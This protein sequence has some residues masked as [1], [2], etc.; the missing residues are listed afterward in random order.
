VVTNIL[1]EPA[2]SILRAEVYKTLHCHN[3]ISKSEFIIKLYDAMDWINGALF[4]A[5]GMTF[6]CLSKTA[7]GFSLLPTR[8]S[9]L[10]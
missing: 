4:L 9:C 2:I 10:G 1:E 6:V 3:Q 7:S 8:F 5:R